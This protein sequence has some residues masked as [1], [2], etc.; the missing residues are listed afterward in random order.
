MRLA[1]QTRGLESRSAVV[2][3]ALGAEN[4]AS[5]MWTKIVSLQPAAGEGPDLCRTGPLD[6][7]AGLGADGPW[8]R[9]DPASSKA[10]GTA[11]IL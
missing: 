2:L 4:L 11:S 5:A 8:R 7:L 1:Q 3:A 9:L 6:R 10:T